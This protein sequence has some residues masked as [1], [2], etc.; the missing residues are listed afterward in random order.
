M[1]TI[2]LVSFVLISQFGCTRDNS[3]AP[4]TDSPSPATPV[5]IDNFTF[6]PSTLTINAGTRVTWTNHDDVPHTVTSTH[7]SKVLASPA[8]DTDEKYSFTF[9]T[10][11]TYPY[12]CTV[13]PHMTG[14]V[15]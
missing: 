12:Y 1:K 4:E 15:I 5:A 14:T 6:S 7:R 9:A 8:L 11:G 2:I 3:R 13:H 10:R